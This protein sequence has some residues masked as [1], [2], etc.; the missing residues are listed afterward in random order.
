MQ[1]RA[2][3]LL[4]LGIDTRLVCF[5]SMSNMVCQC[6]SIITVKVDRQTVAQLLMM[7]ML[8]DVGCEANHRLPLSRKTLHRILEQIQWGPRRAR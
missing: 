2:P 5:R 4:A 1:A 3:P 7:L 6:I 8:G